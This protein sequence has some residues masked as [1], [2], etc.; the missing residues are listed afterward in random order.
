[1]FE[2]FTERARR[3]VIH[4]QQEARREPLMHDRVGTAHLLLGP[5]REE[6]GVA[7]HV[8]ASFDITVERARAQVLGIIAPG[9]EITRGQIPFTPRA[10]AALE[11]APSH[12]SSDTVTSAPNTFCWV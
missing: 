8:L 4:A 9:E 10:K 3:V 6:E 5:L 11:A 1:V 7:P 2:R 12:E